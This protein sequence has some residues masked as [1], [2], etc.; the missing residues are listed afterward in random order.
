VSTAAFHIVLAK[1]S[2]GLVYRRRQDIM[3][4]RQLRQDPFPAGLGLIPR[5]RIA[6][7]RNV[8]GASFK[9]RIDGVQS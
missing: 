2:R 4:L 9:K 6:T 3:T 1:D 8:T 5:G 7:L